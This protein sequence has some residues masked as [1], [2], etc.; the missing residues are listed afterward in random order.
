MK[1]YRRCNCGSRC[2]HL[3][4]YRFWLHGRE[5]RGS[6]HTDNRTLARRIAAKHQSEVLEGRYALRRPR[7]PKLS[8]HI[9][10]YTEWTAKTNRSSNKDPGILV[11]FLSVVGDRRL[12]EFSLF[13]FER[14]KTARAK[15]VRLATVNRELNI[16]RGCF[17]RAVEWGRLGSS[18]R[19]RQT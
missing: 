4:W 10:A 15:D 14:W 19:V 18:P 16:I 9:R 3:Y 12:D 7:T 11:L 17:S 5:Y 1:L 13:H 2:E 6:T 8:D